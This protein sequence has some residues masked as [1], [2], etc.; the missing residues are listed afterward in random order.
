LP[1]PHN[2]GNGSLSDKP[3]EAGIELEQL[4]HG[5]KLQDL[6]ITVKTKYLPE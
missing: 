6:P 4:H 3:G 5:K 1:L 2:D